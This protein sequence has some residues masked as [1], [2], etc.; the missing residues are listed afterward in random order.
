MSSNR[1]RGGPLTEKRS[2]SARRRS[3]TYSCLA[4]G[5]WRNQWICQ[6]TCS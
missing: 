2:R 6:R 1:K 5:W 4:G 3:W